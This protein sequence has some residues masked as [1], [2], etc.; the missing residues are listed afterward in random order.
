M[1]CRPLAEPAAETEAK[2]PNDTFQRPAH[3]VE[4]H[5]Q[6]HNGYA[7]TRVRGRQGRRLP[8]RGRLRN[9]VRA[10]RLVLAERLRTAVAVVAHGGSAHE[11]AR[12]RTCLRQ[13]VRQQRGAPCAAVSYPGLLLFVPAP[14]GDV[15]AREMDHAVDPLERSVV[16]IARLGV[17]ARLPLSRRRLPAA[18][19]EQLRGPRPAAVPIAQSR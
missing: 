7:H 4:R 11:A 12:R 19:G 18:R 3:G 15:L 13:G 14:V 8:F 10:R 1:Y 5:S 16:D 9:E 6:P 2:G 17:P